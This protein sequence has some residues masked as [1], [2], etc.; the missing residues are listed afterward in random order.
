M[1]DKAKIGETKS[2][3]AI[4]YSSAGL[5]RL[6]GRVRSGVRSFE[7]IARESKSGLVTQRYKSGIKRGSQES[8]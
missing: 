5:K 2:P 8:R 6:N 3:G 4:L 1:R 7:G